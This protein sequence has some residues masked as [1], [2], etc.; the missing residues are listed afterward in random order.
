MLYPD[1]AACYT[2]HL[3]RD[4]HVL[5]SFV[6]D[7]SGK[8][9][10]LDLSHIRIFLLHSICIF[11]LGTFSSIASFLWFPGACACRLIIIDALR[12]CFALTALLLRLFNFTW[13]HIDYTIAILLRIQVFGRLS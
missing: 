5:S 2:T 13:I 7:L 12:R 10:V 1:R 11:M 6:Q 9:L 8:I 4:F 3:L